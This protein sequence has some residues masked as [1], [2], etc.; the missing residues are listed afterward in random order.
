MKIMNFMH[1]MLVH[2]PKNMSDCE[3][4]M[5]SSPSKFYIVIILMIFVD[6]LYLTKSIL[7]GTREAFV[8]IERYA[9]E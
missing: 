7:L 1:K 9:K 4:K 6:P 3:F 2:E 5:S 8:D